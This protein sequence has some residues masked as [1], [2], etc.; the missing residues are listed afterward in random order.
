MFHPTDVYSIPS[1]FIVS[2]VGSPVSGSQPSSV[3]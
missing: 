1:A 3:Q 2:A